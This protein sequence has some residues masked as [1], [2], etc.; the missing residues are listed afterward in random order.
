MSIP[1]GFQRILLTAYSAMLEAQTLLP[2]RRLLHERQAERFAALQ[3][4]GVQTLADLWARLST[5]PR[6]AALAQETGIPDDYLTALRRELNAMTPKPVALDAFAVLDAFTAPRLRALG[7]RTNLDALAALQP[8]QGD[9]ARR[10]LDALGAAEADALQCLCVLATL[11][12]VGAAAACALY[13][14]G[15]RTPEQVAAADAAALLAR[16]TQANAAHAY[17][18]AAL[19][20]K[21]AQFVIDAAQ[22]LLALQNPAQ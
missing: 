8:P 13:A 11:N 5:A 22:R 10:I 9:A 15:Y 6:Q 2:G 7:I 4:A 18:A 19:A 21:D 12:G 17:Y 14:A 1:N 16:M 20:Q 3:G